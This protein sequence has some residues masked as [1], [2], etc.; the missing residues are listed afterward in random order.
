[1]NIRAFRAAS[2]LLLCGAFLAAPALA[3]NKSKVAP[4]RLDRMADLLVELVPIGTI[5]ESLAKDDPKWPMQEKPDAVDAKQLACLRGELS[6]S[7]HRR[8]KRKE[9]DAY[10]ETNPSRVS[11][12]IKVM[13][14]GAA[15]LMGK[16]MLAGA[17]QE[18]TGKPVSEEQIMSQATPEQLAAFMSFMTHPDYVGLRRLAGV[19]NAFD[20]QKSAEENEEAGQ[21]V[22]ESLATKVMLN[23]MSACEIPASV[24]F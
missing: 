4:E 6:A 10:A 8:A 1:M 17:E 22:G 21:Q 13:E 18:R 24:L 5:F 15:F 11:E 9:V 12:D 7:G 3:Q 2:V 19:G 20:T 16:L 14:E 23:A